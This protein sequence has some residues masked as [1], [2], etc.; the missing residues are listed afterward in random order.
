MTSRKPPEDEPDNFPRDPLGAGGPD[1][2]KAVKGSM[3]PSQAVTDMQKQANSIGTG[4]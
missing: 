3:P 1:V 2:E 4:L